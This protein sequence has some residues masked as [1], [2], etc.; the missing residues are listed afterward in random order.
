MIPLQDK[1][2]TVPPS[3]DYP[4]GELTDKNGSNP[5][6]P[7]NV[8][9]FNDIMQFAEKLM[10]LA[11]ITPNGLPDNDY[12]GFQ[13][14]EAL[15]TLTVRRKVIPIGAWDMDATATLFLAHGL[16]LGGAGTTVANIRG[17]RC[18]IINDAES[19]AA[20]IDFWNGTI[21]GGTVN[22]SASL[23]TLTRTIAGFFDSTDFNDTGINRGYVIIEYFE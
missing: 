3:G 14:V 21:V 6:T 8:V 9:L 15:L 22:V 4:F 12:S 5:G 1:Q 10:S 18:V 16:D 23:V 17:V 11:G 2:N 7:A 20:E 19:S 13:L